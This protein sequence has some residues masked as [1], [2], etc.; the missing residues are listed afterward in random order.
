MHA[1]RSTLAA[2]AAASVVA[3]FG[4]VGSGQQLPL[5]PIRDRGQAVSPAYEGW[6]R[7]ADGT[8]T[9]LVGYFNRNRAETLDIP[10]GPNNRIE[11]G[12]PDLG[13]PTHFLTRRQ[14]GVFTITVP[15]DFGDRKYTWTITANGE[16]NAVPIGLHPSYEV[17]PFKDPAMGNLPP[18]LKLQP[19]GPDLTGPPRG[20]A[21]TLTARVGE[22]APISFWASDD[23]HQ[24]PGARTRGGPP[25]SVFLSKFRG[26]GAVSFDNARPPVDIKGGGAVSAT[27]TFDAPG[28]YIIRVQANDATGDGGG[29]F[30]CCWT[31]AHVKVTVS[32]AAATR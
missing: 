32:P 16:T 25:V 22:P 31:N 27:A 5:E 3:G 14:W 15:R 13:Q 10:V 9:L 1:N 23:A 20:I 26:P 21:A 19:A 17:Q 8:F 7:N 4:V 30:Q 12:G 24:E 2:F 28:E 29:G 11:P 18:V 6:Y